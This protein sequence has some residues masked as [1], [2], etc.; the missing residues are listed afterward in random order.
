MV[1]RWAPRETTTYNVERKYTVSIST[2]SSGRWRH[3]YALEGAEGALEKKQGFSGRRV[4]R[5]HPIKSVFL[6]TF[7][8]LA[9]TKSMI[10]IRN[11]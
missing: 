4:L 5:A 9:R 3:N 11:Y 1:V 10:L 8:G 6:A 2:N 7:S